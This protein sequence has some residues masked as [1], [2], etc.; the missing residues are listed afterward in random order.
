[1]AT[2]HQGPIWTISTL[3][4]LKTQEMLNSV[5]MALQKA[6][7]ETSVGES[8]TWGHNLPIYWSNGWGR[9]LLSESCCNVFD[10]SSDLLRTRLQSTAKQNKEIPEVNFFPQWKNNPLK[11][12]Q[13]K[14]VLQFSKRNDFGYCL[15]TGNSRI[16]LCTFS[17]N[18]KEQG[19]TSWKARPPPLSTPFL[20]CWASKQGFPCFRMTE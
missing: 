6:L 4:P 20:H 19:K 15:A 16:W 3:L 8:E 18:H 5:V 11:K 2:F 12:K 17:C 14:T 13:H 9:H 7:P 1:M 10:A